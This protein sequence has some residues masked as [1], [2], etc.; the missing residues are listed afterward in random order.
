LSLLIKPAS[1]LCN[2]SCSYCFYHSLS[3]QRE[4]KSFGLMTQKTL[5]NT[6]SKALLL[7]NESLYICFQ[8]GEPTIAGIGFF[9]EAVKLIKKYNI[10]NIPV[11][12]SLQT[13]GLLLNEEWAVFFKENNF[14][15]GLSLD[16]PSSVHDKTRLDVNGK[17]TFERVLKAAKLLETFKVDFNILCVVNKYVAQDIRK[18]YLFFKKNNFKFLQFIPCL[19][20]L[21]SSLHKYEY[22]LTPKDYGFFLKSSFDLWFNDLVAGQYTSIRQFDNFVKMLH[23]YPPESCGMSGICASYFLV[24]SGGQTY[25]CDFYAVEKWHLGNINESNFREMSK[26]KTARLFVES[27]IQI[28]KEC[29][30]CQWFD[31]CRGGCRRNREPEFNEILPLNTYCKSY[32]DFFEYAMPRLKT[33]PL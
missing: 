28:A 6:I 3:N 8:G 26:T 25:P 13:N 5:E 19:D 4:Q 12:L 17:G 33:I 2:L 22:S 32:K 11:T 21:D 10:F 1:S 27:S 29:D 9:K 30:A 14:L 15:L 7:A 24:E 16:G 23:G 20:P 31:I 18:V